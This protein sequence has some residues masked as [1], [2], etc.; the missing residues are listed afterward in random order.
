M[1]KTTGIRK[2]PLEDYWYDFGKKLVEHAKVCE[3]SHVLDI[4]FGRGTSLIP[5][6]EMVGPG[7]EVV[8]IDNWDP[9][10][11]CTTIE[12]ERHGLTNATVVNMDARK[13]DFD[14][15]SF[16]FI[17]SGFS[18][19]FFS[20]ADTN[21]LLRDGGRIALSSWALEEDSEWMGEL[22]QSKFPENIY[23][24]H[25]DMNEPE[26]DD[27]PRVY[28]RDTA[29]SLTTKL[30]NAGFRDV[31]V[32]PEEKRYAFGSEEAWWDS[33]K[34]S[35]WQGCL[36]RI[37]ETGAGARAAFKKEAFRMLQMH[38]VGDSYPY[39]RAVLFGVGTK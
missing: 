10:V 12:I 3:G 2:N 18:Y 23:A 38:R 37:D 29:D 33:M 22:I 28:S 5:A 24:G 7:G 20:L 21:R 35:G 1:A 36:K 27:R 19:V 11:K 13:I 14:D 39:T 26:E 34:H 9:H 31:R 30:R 16:D 32:L 8:G 17:L 15:N 25:E 4:G 6:A